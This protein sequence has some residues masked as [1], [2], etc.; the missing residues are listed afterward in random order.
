MFHL[1]LPNVYKVLSNGEIKLEELGGVYSGGKWNFGGGNGGGGNKEEGGGGGEEKNKS[2]ESKKEEEDARKKEIVVVSIFGSSVHQ[3]VGGRGRY[4]RAFQLAL[5]AFGTVGMYGR[6]EGDRRKKGNSEK[7]GNAGEG[8]E[9][10]GDVEKETLEDDRGSQSH[11]TK[12]KISA[13]VS[14]NLNDI[15]FQIKSK[16]KG[17]IGSLFCL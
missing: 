14:L 6:G 9:K 4:K 13:G 8:E 12:A 15:H 3:A 17:C 10:G 7:E 16:V 5:D 1:D 11:L 2:S